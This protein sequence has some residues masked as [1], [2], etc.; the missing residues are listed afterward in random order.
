VT[1]FPLDAFPADRPAA[2]DD[3]GQVLSYGDLAQ[4]SMRLASLVPTRTVALVLVRN[5]LG[6]VSAIVALIKQGVVPILL[7][8][9]AAQATIALHRERYQPDVLVLPSDLQAQYP[10]A[11]FLLTM[12]DYA[13]LASACEASLCPPHPD[14][15]LLLSTSGSTGSPK[16]VRQ[17][18]QNVLSNAQAIA[19]YLKIGPGDRPVTTLPLHYTYGF[20]VLSSHLQVGATLLVTERSVMEKPFWTFLKEGGATSLAGV[21]YTYQ[22]LKRLGFLR[23]DPGAL[24]TLTQAGGKLS[25]ALVREF[26]EF[27]ALSGIDFYVMYGQTEATARMSYVPAARALEKAGSIGVAIPGGE[28]FLIDPTGGE[29][30][31]IDV[32]GELGYRGPN[33]TMGYAEQRT[34]LSKGD[35]LQGIL[36]TGDLALRDSD[37]YYYIT[38]RLSRFAKLFGKRVSLDDLEQICM[39]LVTEVACTEAEAH[40]MVWITD[41]QHQAALPSLLA[42]RTAIHPLSFQV[43]VIDSLPRTQTGK[44]DYQRLLNEVLA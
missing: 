32:K 19:S 29:I 7:D 1:L 36:R 28:L 39:G 2:L 27:A 21:P 38:G 4:I 43:R 15:A 11:P 20:S 3:S 8:A 37:G 26:A 9:S 34:D 25:D 23:M 41:G 18:R 33:V 17:S 13:V 44:T 5:T 30:T 12:F 24:R 31:A 6:C 22:M 10:D 42:Q 40:V 16:L 35:E 14:L